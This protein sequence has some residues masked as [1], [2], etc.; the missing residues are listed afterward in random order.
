MAHAL[1][2]DNMTFEV[3]DANLQAA[4]DKAIETVR[5]EGARATADIKAKL[6]AETKAVAD[7]KA[8][9]SALQAKHDGLIEQQKVNEEKHKTEIE[10]VK[11][12]G[13]E[14]ADLLVIAR[15]FLG[16]NEKLDGVDNLEIRRRVILKLS[17][18]AKLDGK[19]ESYILARFDGCIEAAPSHLDAARAAATARPATHR[20]DSAPADPDT[21]RQKMIERDRQRERDAQKRN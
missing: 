5:S 12:D 14:R 8:A 6:D 9:L 16:E 11:R 4:F 1:K 21:A 2:I 19:D 20:D 15:R 3:A 10:K 17:P 13:T 18:G 7:A